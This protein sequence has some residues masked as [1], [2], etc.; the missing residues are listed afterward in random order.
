MPASAS[1]AT[2]PRV[3]KINADDLSWALA[4]GWTDFN[5][6]RGDLIFVALLYPLI[7]LLT[8]AF[9]MNDAALPLFFP[10]VAGLSI[11]GP[12]VASGFYELARRR[13]EHL[14]SSWWHFF[15]PL[16]G[17]NGTTI[18]TLTVGLALLFILWLAAAYAIYAA[19]MGPDFP[20]GIAAFTSRVFGTPEGWALIALGNL[21]GLVFAVIVLVTTL[22][23][24]PMAVDRTVDPGT[25][26]ATSL[27]A[28]QANPGIVAGWGLRVAGL[29]AL[30][31]FPAFIGLAVVL[32]VLGYATWHLYTRMVVRG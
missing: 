30:G 11:L 12:A 29:L 13:E 7:G 10:L 3:R 2:P 6:K 26:V 21:A 24:F 25:A 15:D 19:T 31:C 18:V 20:V 8:A 28:V 5:A 9:A 32:P 4:E 17:S 1:S 23:S 27:R 22:I 14:E 16:R